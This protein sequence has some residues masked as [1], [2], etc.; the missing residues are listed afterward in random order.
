MLDQRFRQNSYSHAVMID[1]DG[2]INH[3]SGYTHRVDELEFL[4]GA[5]DGLRLLAPLA[6][7]IIILTNQSGI[8]LGLYTRNTM[9]QFHKELV[10]SIEESG[11][12]IDAIYFSPYYDLNSLPANH[13]LHPSTKPNPGMLEEAASDFQLNL[14]K[15]WMVGD[16]ITDIIAG[17]QAGAKTI[18]ISN[19]QDHHISS[20]PEHKPQVI[21][22]NLFEAAKYLKKCWPYEISAFS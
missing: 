4:E 9:S 11:G 16:R 14:N 13:E 18:L 10:K 8:A 3:D 5:L 19:D 15:V 1:R 12:R 2:T 17:K 22:A 20:S 21:V 6:I 7:N